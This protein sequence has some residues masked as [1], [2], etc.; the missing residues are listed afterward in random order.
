MEKNQGASS[1]ETPTQFGSPRASPLQSS[2]FPRYGT[3]KNIYFFFTI[4][5]KHK[6]LFLLPRDERQK[7]RHSPL[8]PSAVLLFVPRVLVALF[9]WLSLVGI[10]L[11]LFY[12]FSIA[13]CPCP[14]GC[15]GLESKY[16]SFFFYSRW[17]TSFFSLL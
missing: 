12:I 14:L 13:G 17:R 11:F 1:K 8:F 2:A 5:K 3:L 6:N 4:I 9:P 10:Q 16:F 7:E 15:L